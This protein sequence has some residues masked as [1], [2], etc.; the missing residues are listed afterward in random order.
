MSILLLVILA[1][2]QVGLI[3]VW[4]VLRD[5]LRAIKHQTAL[6]ELDREERAELRQ[7]LSGR[8]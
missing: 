3:V 6:D 7:P 1:V 2:L 4:L 8:R 5:I